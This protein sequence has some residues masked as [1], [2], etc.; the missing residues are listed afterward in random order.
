MEPHSRDHMRLPR[1][2][3]PRRT[4]GA[5]P[6]LDIEIDEIEGSVRVQDPRLF[7]AGRRAFCRRLLEAASR[8]PG[9]RRAEVQ[10]GTASCLIEFD[11]GSN[12]P[13]AMADAFVRA[14]REAS[15]ATLRSE[16]TPWWRRHWGW[17]TLTAFRLVDSASLWET[18]EVKTGRVRLRHPELKGDRARLSRLADTLA[19]LDG[20]LGCCV[21]P[22]SRRI[23]IDY[24]PES[25][26]AN[27]LLDRVEQALVNLE[28]SGLPAEPET[29]RAIAVATIGKRFAY[30][31]LAGGAFAM[32]LVGRAMPG[33]AS[34]PW[35]VA[36]SHYLARSSPRL[37]ERLR[38]T[39]FFGPI[40]QEWEYHGGLSRSS[41]GKLAGLTLTIVTVTV[42][43]SPLTPVALVLIVL[44]STS[45]IYGIARM[46]ALGDDLHPEPRLNGQAHLAL[47]AP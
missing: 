10:L 14:V 30:L 38:R 13:E 47:P 5:F 9:I 41:K 11:A 4:D 8:Q 39:A 12:T 32:T 34:A 18:V 40:L 1:R 42:V 35:L 22:L 25:P 26:L 15:A 23:T 37:N 3:E 21:F 28:A 44:I 17:S 33:M 2:I 27:H 46:P 19:G 36:T 29:G 16:R 43:L 31:A 6:C 20:V 24:C 7:H 45:S